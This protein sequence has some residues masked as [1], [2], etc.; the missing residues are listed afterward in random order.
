MA[1]S[2]EQQRQKLAVEIS[3]THVIRKKHLALR[4]GKREIDREINKQAEPIVEPLN[5]LIYHVKSM[6]KDR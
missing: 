2:K 4:L 6:K 5:Q 3:K 1:S